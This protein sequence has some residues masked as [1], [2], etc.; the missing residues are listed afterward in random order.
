LA[1]KL[2]AF[3]KLTKPTISLLVIITGAT[4]LVME[5]S[6]VSDPLRFTL[7]LLGLFLASGSANAL[8]QYFERDIDK[9]MTRTAR[10]R[11]IAN[12]TLKPSEALVFAVSIG[13]LGVGLFAYAFNLLSA[14]LAAGTILFYAFYYTL[15][16]KPRTPWNIVIGGAAGAMGPLIAWAAAAGTLTMTPWLLFAVIFF[17]TP[18]HFWALALCLKEDYKAVRY[19]MMPLV[20]GDEETLRQML[21]Y[22]VVTVGLTLALFFSGVGLLYLLLAAG[23]GIGFLYLTWHLAATREKKDAWSLFGY[24]IVYLLVLFV[25]LMVDNRFMIQPWVG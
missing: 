14:A 18:P 12:G 8:N 9:R 22:T 15:Y 10:K 24:S 21:W 5:G 13:I 19:P 6:F 7:V 1:S 16:L 11:P 2:P 25:G 17:W 23:L 20:A 4:A 3:L